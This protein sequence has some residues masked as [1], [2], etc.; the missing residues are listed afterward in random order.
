MGYRAALQSALVTIAAL[1]ALPCALP[2]RSD[3]LEDDSR[4]SVVIVQGQHR[5]P[6]SLS[7][8]HAPRGFRTTA[9]TGRPAGV[10]RALTGGPGGL[11]DSFYQSTVEVSRRL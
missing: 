8:R 9:I 1:S 3:D 6:K 10:D 2:C 11:P 4:E 5:R 7:S